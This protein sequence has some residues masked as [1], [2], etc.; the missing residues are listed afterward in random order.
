MNKFVTRWLPWLSA[1]WVVMGAQAA[2]TATVYTPIQAVPPN[3]ISLPARPAIMLNMSKDHQLFYR[4]YNEFTDY[5]GDGL[6]DRS[7]IHA[8]RY[9]GYFDPTKCY[10]YSNTT[11]RFAPV[12]LANA[13]TN[14][15]SGQWSGNF[16]N[17]ATM[18]RMD[19]V[20]KVLYGGHRSTDGVPVAGT[21]L[22]VL[23]RASLPMDAHSFAK[24][25]NGSDI[26]SL[27]P[28]GAIA[29]LTLC[30]TTWADNNAWSHLTTNPP[31]LRAARGNFA[32]WNAHERRQCRWNE[33]TMWDQ[34]GGGNGNTLA[35]TGLAAS[36]GYPSF[37]TNGLT[38]AATGG[39]NGDFEVKVEVCNA[40]LLG[41]ERCR[42]YPNGNYKPIGLLQEYGEND[43][44][45]FGLLTGSFSRNIS[46]G[47]L[48]K[49]VS[50]FRDEVN[51]ATD[52]TFTA[53]N[54]IVGTLN[55]IR[56]YGYRYSD[57]SYSANE[58][59][60]CTFQLSGLT[61]NQCASWG[62]PIGE[63]FTEA[64]RYFKGPPAT[65]TYGP[66]AAYGASADPKGDLMGLPRPA[67]TDPFNRGASINTTFGFPQCRAINV[68]NFNAS[69]ISYDNDTQAPFSD[70]GAAGSLNSYID[71]VGSGEGV[72]NTLK[73]VGRVN[74]AGDSSCTAKTVGTLSQVDGLCPTGPAYR[75][76]FSLAGAAL[77]AHTNPIRTMSAFPLTDNL[78]G[79]NKDPNFR[80][81]SFSVALAP[82]L[83]RIEVVA[84][85]RRAI[86]Q[87]NYMLNTANNGAKRGN[88]TLVDFRVVSQ[89]ATSGKY[90]VIWEDSEQGGDYDQDAS[91]ILEWSLSGTTLTVTTSTFADATANPQ[92]FGYTISGT[93]KDGVHYHS[94]I[95]GFSFTDPTNL[96][97]RLTSG[98]VHPNINASGGCN[99]CNRN[100]PP[101]RATYTVVGSSVN[102]LEDPLFYAAKWG[103][104][105]FAAGGTPDTPDVSSKWDTRN[106][107]GAIVAGGDGVPDN[108]FVVFN[109]DQLEAALR[110]VFGDIL[111][112]S[113]ASPAVSTGQLVQGSF[114]YIAEFDQDAL[115]GDVKAF[116]VTNTGAFAT[117]ATWS[118][119][120]RLQAVTPTTRQVI[121][122]NDQSGLAFNWATINTNAAY[123]AMLTGGTNTLSATDARDLVDYMRGVRTREGTATPWRIRPAINIAGPIVN[124]APWVQS[125]P[126]ANYADANFPGYGDFFDANAARTQLLW[127]A[128]NDGMLH[129]VNAATGAPVL[130]YVPGMLAP[131]LN[132]QVQ[133]GL[134]I[135]AFVDGSPFTGDVWIDQ[136]SVTN[137][138][139]EWRT[140]LFGTL[141]R[142]GRGVYALDVTQTANLTAGNAANVF[143]WQF[144][145][146]DDADLGYVVSDVATRR[147]SRQ[148]API[149][150][151]NNGQ[152][153]IIVGNGY[154]SVSGKAALMILPADGPNALTGSWLNRY[155]KVVADAGTGNGLSTPTWVDLD[156]NGTAD[157]VY[158]GDLKGNLWKFNISSATPS[159]WSVAYVDAT[160][161]APLYIAQDAA[162]NM[163]PITAAPET[164]FPSFG[165]VMVTFATGLANTSAEFPRPGVTQRIFSIWDRA[166]FAATGAANRALPRNETTLVPRTYVR[167]A[168]GRVAVAAAAAIDFT[169]GVA[170]NAKDG[171][172][173]DLPG[174]SEMVLSNLSLR[175]GNI[176]MVSVRPN[177]DTQ[178]CS[179]LPLATLYI[180]DP[181]SGTPLP[182]VLGSSGTRA[183]VG[184]VINDQ[185]V[186]FV[187]D[188]RGGATTYGQDSST[189]YGS[190]TAK[191]TAIGANTDIAV[192][193][194]LQNT[195]IQW[196]EIP[197]LRTQ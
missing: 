58:D 86:I 92:G 196:R 71:A 54:G 5:S 69:V 186:S 106:A 160:G 57:S 162:D 178:S 39:T 95:L 60:V 172:Y 99:L 3:A 11:R 119:G 2:P 113:N 197:G 33:E 165:G 104:F 20:R 193:Y 42:R 180:F 48:R 83:P 177:A 15:C 111:A 45:E 182:P 75:G 141:G 134:G 142:G 188:A 47:V 13:T 63:M 50:T 174:S 73:F 84:G 22:T 183:V 163:L 66:A 170:A 72:N 37:A 117:A 97:V 53:T 6:P 85:T 187:S 189:G 56:V 175:A 23:E 77:W 94:G 93:N 150:K 152:S 74:A 59:G 112:T 107:A 184:V 147:N 44:A 105:E 52:G 120:E 12:A 1:L 51:H 146:D 155:F 131:R 128:S 124:A 167:E 4:A 90:I 64:L 118:L 137:R 121:T 143:K 125:A 108:Y 130:S 126:A 14:Y 46:G 102:D 17:W 133:N 153:A 101:S 154:Q 115:S 159:E 100:D 27:T 173:A 87:P 98:A 91:G 25:Y 41:S 138:A 32:L 169:N 62:N 79:A 144:S 140:Y 191:T 40:A 127:A 49:N 35:A 116:Q 19:V 34:D 110:R 123:R 171:W 70:L 30:N 65:G 8:V 7:Y 157:I 29:E 129:A 31:L 151:L 168:D 139:L 194:G 109:P 9:S 88:G 18:T 28:F 81:D 148:A 10:S 43:R 89:T 96:N 61:D 68:I 26:A 132:E 158:A 82:G 161:P 80:V 149:V 190:S 179:Q 135:R 192:G 24:Y 156:N 16:L 145:A 166:A 114:K 36:A 185:K 181:V 78:Y 38:T 195:R 136:P 21:S 122:N 67:W 55:R 164:S 103:G 76:S 176:F